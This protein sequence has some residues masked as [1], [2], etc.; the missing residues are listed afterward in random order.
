MEMIIISGAGT[1][2]LL[3]ALLFDYVFAPALR[4]LACVDG[5]PLSSAPKLSVARPRSPDHL[6]TYDRAA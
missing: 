6:L 5:V 2:V 4:R 1:L 3:V